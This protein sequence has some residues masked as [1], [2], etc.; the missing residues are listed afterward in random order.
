MT[1][2]TDPV[3]V[4]QRELLDR[5]DRVE[6]IG[7]IAGVAVRAARRAL[8][9]IVTAVIDPENDIP[10]PRQPIDICDVSF[11]RPVLR[12]RDVAV[13]EDDGGPTAG[14][15]VA[16]GDGQQSVDLEPFR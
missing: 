10:R 11:G 1:P 15:R 5:R 16:I 13:V 12:G 9:A 7:R 6:H 8:R 3:R 2:H 4:C 14:W